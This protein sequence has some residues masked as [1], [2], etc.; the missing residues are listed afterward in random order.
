MKYVWILIT[1][2][3][4]WL[5]FYVGYKIDDGN[6]GWWSLPYVMTCATLLAFS[7]DKIL[8]YK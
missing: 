7:I 2:I 1:L 8:K 5:S 4:I 6:F 3:I